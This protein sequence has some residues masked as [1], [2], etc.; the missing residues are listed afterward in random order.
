MKTA[1]YCVDYLSYQWTST[2]DLITTYKEIC[3]QRQKYV[4]NH[5]STTASLLQK[6]QKKLKKSEEYKLKRFQN[7]LWRTMA[8]NCTNHLGKSNK[9]INPATVSW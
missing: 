3:K 5:I 1:E 2:D 6:N 8:K 9:L 7:A 4:V